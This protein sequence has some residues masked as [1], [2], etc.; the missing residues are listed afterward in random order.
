MK[1]YWVYWRWGVS[2]NHLAKLSQLFLT[3]SIDY[4]Y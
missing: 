4:E 3:V 2:Y 1:V